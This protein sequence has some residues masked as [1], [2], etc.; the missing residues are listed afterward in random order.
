MKSYDIIRTKWQATFDSS[1]VS[2]QTFKDRGMFGV[3]CIDGLRSVCWKVYLDCLPSLDTSSWSLALQQQRQ[4][5]EDLKRKFVFDP[6]AEETAQKAQDLAVNNPLSLDQESPWIQYFKDGEL[7]KIIKQDVERTFP[8]YEYFHSTTAQKRLI[9]MLFIYCKLHEDVSYR[10]GMHELLAPILQI[11][12]DECLDISSTP[13]DDED[14]PLNLIKDVLDPEYVEHDTFSLFTNLMKSAKQWYEF[15]DE[16]SNQRTLQALKTMGKN[17]DESN[18]LGNQAAPLT[19]NQTPIMVKCNRIHHELLKTYDPQLYAYLESLQ[20]EPQLYGIRWLRLLFGREFPLEELPRLWDGIFAD[21]SDLGLVDYICVAMLLYIREDLLAAD[22][23]MCLHRIMKFPSVPD[24]TLF[25]KQ[26]L[27]L[28][29]HPTFDGGSNI[30]FQYAKNSGRQAPIL[31]NYPNEGS[32]RS[33]KQRPRRTQS[34]TSGILTVPKPQVGNAQPP[35]KRDE[36]I[37]QLNKAMHDIK[38]SVNPLQSYLKRTLS[39]SQKEQQDSTSDGPDFKSIYEHA[40][41]QSSPNI[42]PSTSN[43]SESHDPPKPL[44]SPTS[45]EIGSLLDKCVNLLEN[46]IFGKSLAQSES[47]ASQNPGDQTPPSKSPDVMKNE[48]D[49]VTALVGLKHVRDV[50]NRVTTDLN[51]DILNQQSPQEADDHWELVEHQ[52]DSEIPQ[53]PRDIPALGVIVE[54]SPELDPNEVDEDAQPSPTKAEIPSDNALPE[55]ALINS[56]PNDWNIPNTAAPELNIHDDPWKS[57]IEYHVP[58]SSTTIEDTKEH[59]ENLTQVVSQTDFQIESTST[60]PIEA[61]SP[62]VLPKKTAPKVD[63]LS[64]LESILAEDTPN[65]FST[66]PNYNWIFH[67][68][69]E[70]SIGDGRASM[71]F[72]R[73]GSVENLDRM[74]QS[75]DLEKERRHRN[76]PTRTKKL[77]GKSVANDSDDPLKSRDVN[78]RNLRILDDYA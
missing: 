60:T 71:S 62:S 70:S 67:G 28:R 47:S 23:A 55:P 9:D 24:P 73:S 45:F 44:D 68:K 75:L 38:K 3:S 49:I 39:Y 33:V 54:T 8:D 27:H 22:Y 72:T 78:R 64:S 20:I 69:E 53:S 61:P 7:R 74:S 43:K 50:L 76:I 52:S 16:L 2:L 31:F 14:L 18:L 65:R 56:N 32:N 66:N 26:A 11:V 4:Y 58:S 35:R 77:V 36:A 46:G 42:E 6:N 13:T 5:Y 37:A 17:L 51:P 15:N 25:I 10:Q 21:S 19:P 29:D 41:P 1:S 34:D 63:V 57:E 30:I 48:M 12:D 59:D 40:I